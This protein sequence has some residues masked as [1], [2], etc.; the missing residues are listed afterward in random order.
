[1]S[2]DLTNASTVEESNVKVVRTETNEYGESIQTVRPYSLSTK[3]TE[4]I[5]GNLV[6]KFQ[7]KTKSVNASE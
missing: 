6:N 5:V 1:M 3:T 4:E 2:S 7:Y